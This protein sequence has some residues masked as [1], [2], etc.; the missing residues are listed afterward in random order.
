[1]GTIFWIVVAYS[2]VGWW[3]FR[4]AVRGLAS[5]LFAGRD[6][7]EISGGRLAIAMTV[8]LAGA[9]LSGPMTWGNFIRSWLLR[10]EEAS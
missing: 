8:L 2:L 1:M 10:R 7:V 6:E 3:L 9:V 4:V 5:H